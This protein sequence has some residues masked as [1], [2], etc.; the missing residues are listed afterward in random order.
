[1]ISLKP[2]YAMTISIFLLSQTNG[3]QKRLITA[4]LFFEY[5]LPTILAKR[6]DSV[7]FVDQT[8]A[9]HPLHIPEV[10]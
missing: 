3:F 2:N 8:H 6:Y 10:K 1:M 7:L 5:L 4:D 9:L